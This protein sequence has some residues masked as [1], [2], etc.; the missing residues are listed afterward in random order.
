M[1]RDLN[2]LVTT[3]G[4]LPY[5]FPAPAGKRWVID[6]KTKQVKLADQ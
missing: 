6:V 2:E 1:P 4:Y 5:I 3:P